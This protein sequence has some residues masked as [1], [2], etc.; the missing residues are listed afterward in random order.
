VQRALLLV[1]FALSAELHAPSFSLVRA[2]SPFAHTGFAAQFLFDLRGVITGTGIGLAMSKLNGFENKSAYNKP[3]KDFVASDNFK[4]LRRALQE[5][6]DSSESAFSQS[7]SQLS[8]IDEA[9]MSVRNNP[10]LLKMQEILKDHFEF[11]HKHDESTR[12]IVFS[13]WRES[14]DEIVSLL[15]LSA[16]IKPRAFVGQGKGAKSGKKGMNQVLQQEA[17]AEVRSLSVREG[18]LDGSVMIYTVGSPYYYYAT[19]S[20]I[21]VLLLCDW[22]W[23][24]RITIMRLAV[25]SPYYYYATGR[26][27]DQ[28]YA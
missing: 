12:A 25:G 11:A 7:Q 16:I 24:L 1:C 2:A 15:K 19:G 21:S 3:H 20:G 8:G 18:M 26:I 13:Q 22:Q 4:I 5:A 17:I 14:V 9:P 6:G 23:D 27:G 28:R 10:K